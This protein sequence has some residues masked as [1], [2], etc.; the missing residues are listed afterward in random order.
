MPDERSPGA[1]LILEGVTL[2]YG[3]ERAL[4]DVSLQIE[5]GELVTLLGPSGSGKTSTLNVVAGFARPTAGHVVVNGR[6]IEHVRPHKRN[7]GIVFQHYALFPHMSAFDNVAFPLR[8][9]GKKGSELARRVHEALDLVSLHG[10]EKSYPSQLSGGQQQRVALARALVSEPSLLLMDEPLGA[11]DRALRESL[12]DEIRRL[13]RELQITCVYVTHDQDEALALSTRIAVFRN[14]K[15]QQVGSPEQLYEAPTS[16]F[17]ADFLGDSTQI[18]GRVIRGGE[19][20]TIDASQ[21]V[22][23]ASNPHGLDAGAEGVIVVRPEIMRVVPR[24]VPESS[25]SNSVTAR[26]IDVT[27]LGGQC[28]IEVERANGDRGIVR[29][30]SGSGASLAADAL[31][32]LEWS[33]EQSVLLA[34]DQPSVRRGSREPEMQG[35]SYG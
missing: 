9:R 30:A 6:A 32:R 3:P 20:A 25:D 7:I 5:P 27:Y 1:S 2:D 18:R 13:Q 35:V 17:V 28:R 19:V 16:L 33:A 29:A 24:S 26:V 34:P 14:G 10:Q 11:L 8:R 23:S 31:V 22:V 15:I 12:Q 21:V 4:S